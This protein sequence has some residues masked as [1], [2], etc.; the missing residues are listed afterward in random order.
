MVPA[1][2]YGHWSQRAKRVG[3]VGQ[4]AHTRW[5]RKDVED[6]SLLRCRERDL[7]ALKTNKQTKKTN[8]PITADFTKNP[9]INTHSCPAFVFH[10]HSDIY[11]IFSA[12]KKQ[13]K[14]RGSKTAVK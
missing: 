12:E 14:N 11:C 10:Q 2:L 13:R 7:E 4:H 5:H 8:T 6:L 3:C 1:A 9:T